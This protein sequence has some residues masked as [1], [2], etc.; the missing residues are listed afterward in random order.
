MILNSCTNATNSTMLV[1]L[2]L[3]IDLNNDIVEY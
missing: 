3:L 2:V 1:V